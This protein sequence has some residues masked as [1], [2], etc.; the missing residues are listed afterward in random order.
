M[1]C[2][3]PRPSGLALATWTAGVTP[4]VHFSSPRTDI[5]ERKVKVGRRVETRL[6][7]PPLRAHA[8]LVDPIAFEHF[9]LDT[10]AGVRD[11][12]VTLEVRQR[13]GSTSASRSAGQARSSALSVC[14][15]AAS[16]SKGHERRIN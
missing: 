9:L 5:E 14:L 10:A 13:S 15:P 3:M 12:D 8:A 11:F 6:V 7:L 4:K 2:P 16:G 1:G